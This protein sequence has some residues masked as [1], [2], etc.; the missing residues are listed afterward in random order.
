MRS[1]IIAGAV[2]TGALLVASA[3]SASAHHCY[4]DK[5]QDAAY[6]HHLAGG[7]AWVPISDLGE[8]FLVP[9]Q[10]QEACGYVADLAT[11]DFMAAHGMTQEPLIHSKAITGSGAYNKGKAPKPF[12]YLS[13]SDFDELGGYLFGHLEEC[14]AELEE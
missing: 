9:P 2:L 5:W 1:R 10:W 13:D 4:K 11:R 8:E 12:S 14:A 6:Q 7:T 3:G